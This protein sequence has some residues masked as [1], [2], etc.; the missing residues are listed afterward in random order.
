MKEINRSSSGF[1]L[2]EIAVV[3]GIFS[4]LVYLASVSFINLQKSRL[5]SDYLWQIVSTLRQAQSRAASAGT[6]NEQYLRFGIFFNQ[7]SYQEFST[8]TDYSGRQTEAD[9]MTVL[10]SGLVFVNVNLPDQCLAPH[11]CIFFSAPEGKPSANGSLILRNEVSGEQK[12]I[13]INEQ[14]GIAF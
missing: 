5:L 10:P 11:D 9:F 3:A 1:T 7:N 13:S 4:F 12:M 8:T 14:G 6:V 2:M